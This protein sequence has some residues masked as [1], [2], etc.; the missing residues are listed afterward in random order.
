MTR[1]FEFELTRV[2]D[3][4]YT[5]TVY[6]DGILDED[7]YGRGICRWQLTQARV[8]L[9]AT[10]VPRETLFSASISAERCC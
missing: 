4:E 7:Y 1:M 6:A 2:S 8:Q 5:G 10:G 3:V 9:K